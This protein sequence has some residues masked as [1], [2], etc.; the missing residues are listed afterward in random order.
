M[1]LQFIIR[2]IQ[3]TTLLIRF[4]TQFW[5]NP[6][7]FSIH[8]LHPDNGSVYGLT[9]VHVTGFDFDTLTNFYVIQGTDTIYPKTTGHLNSSEAVIYLDLKDRALGMYDIHAVKGSKTTIME[10]GFEVM[11][12]EDGFEDPWVNIDIVSA[13]LTRR[14]TSLK[15]N[16]GN[17]ANT[18]GFDYWLVLAIDNTTGDLSSLNTTYVGSSEEERNEEFGFDY[19]LPGDSTFIDVE[20]TR[21]YVYWLP[22]LAA[23]SQ[24]NSYLSVEPLPG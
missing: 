16:Y 8:S 19:N 11:D 3:I 6:L 2:L 12:N 9:T 20:G 10:D 21:F 22:K 23:K 7:K 18:D 17:Y 5:P 1:Y 4:L 15:I 13:E 14:Y 24:N